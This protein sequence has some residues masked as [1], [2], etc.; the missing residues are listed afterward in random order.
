MGGVVQV[1]D[2]EGGQPALS[3]AHQFAPAAD[4]EVAHRFGLQVGG[5]TVLI[6]SGSRGL[7]HQICDESLR[8]MLRASEKHGIDLPDRQLCA[9]PLRS[10]E[11][12]RYFSDNFDVETITLDFGGSV[13]PP[14]RMWYS[15]SLSIAR[16][17]ASLRWIS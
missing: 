8:R 16:H 1:G 3:G 12:R 13:P 11:A 7:G 5:V 6:H 10:D 17:S 15:C 4:V 9:A 14:R 2:A